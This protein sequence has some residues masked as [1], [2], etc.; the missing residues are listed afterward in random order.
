MITKSI[1][2]TYA[3][4]LN[5]FLEKLIPTIT[6]VFPREHDNNISIGLQHDNA[7]SHFTNNDDDWV[8]AMGREVNWRFTTRQFT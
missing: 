4:Y 8:N 1:N 3:V 6:Q 2:V 7:P 5:Y